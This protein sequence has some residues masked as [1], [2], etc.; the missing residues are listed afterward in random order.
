MLKCRF[1]CSAV[2]FDIS[3]LASSQLL[4]FDLFPELPGLSSMPESIWNDGLSHGL[5]F[6]ETSHVLMFQFFSADSS[7]MVSFMC[8][9][10]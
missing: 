10:D 1:H 6:L 4:D 9:P 8:Q 5:H 2:V 7:V 3:T